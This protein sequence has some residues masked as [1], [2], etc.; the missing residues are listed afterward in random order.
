MWF[1]RREY[2]D[3]RNRNRMHGFNQGVRIP[4]YAHLPTVPTGYWHFC[5]SQW[6]FVTGLDVVEG[7]YKLVPCDEHGNTEVT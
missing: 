7:W 2:F 5:E 6:Q 3:E 1:E 4:G